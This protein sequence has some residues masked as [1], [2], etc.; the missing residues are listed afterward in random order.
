MFY[1]GLFYSDGAA[2]GANPTPNPAE[3]TVPKARLDEEAQRRRALEVELGQLRGKLD[4]SGKIGE[5]LDRVRKGEESWK[6]KYKALE[7]QIARSSAAR[8]AG[9]DDD[10]GVEIAHVLFQRAPADKRGTFEDWLGGLRKE[11]AEV[12]K[13][14]QPYLKKA[15]AAQEPSAGG[16]TGG[17]FLPRPAVPS[18]APT[19][20]ASWDPNVMGEVLKRAQQ[21]DLAAIEQLRKATGR[22]K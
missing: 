21:G 5:E 9:I 10:E 4:E 7:G 8:K 6:E 20:K 11:G 14:L 17:G 2:G 15:E 16:Q 12:P 1:R 19:G 3:P 13:P 22:T 18:G